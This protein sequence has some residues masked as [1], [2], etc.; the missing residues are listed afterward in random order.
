MPYILVY[1]LQ[2]LCLIHII[3]TRRS[4][5]WIYIIIF[6]PGIGG[7]AY[8]IVEILPDLFSRTRIENA[9]DSVIKIIKPSQ[10]F[11]ELE[12]KAKF[13][14]TFTNLINY[15][16]ALMEK[17]RYA[18]ALEIYTSQN[19]SPFLDD[20][21][22]LYKISAALYSTEEYEESLKIL[23]KLMQKDEM[24][25]KSPKINI[26]YLAVKERTSGTDEVKKEYER[27]LASSYDNEIQIAFIKFL[28]KNNFRDE[29]SQVFERINYDER[30]L[31]IS[32]TWYDKNFYKEIHGLERQFRQKK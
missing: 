16:D 24:L 14:A 27:I 9:R 3:K 19:K 2:L 29:L 28:W 8:L 30:T 22:L 23:N 17:K 11:E 26:L 6:L 15:A 32:R 12:Q 7:L 31:K 21:E 4:S 5:M 25:R 10:K 1:V 20:S 18:E 13:S